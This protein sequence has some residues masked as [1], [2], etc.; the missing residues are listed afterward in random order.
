MHDS[1]FQFVKTEKVNETVHENMLVYF[2]ISL[3][4]R[5]MEAHKVKKKKK[6]YIV[7]IQTPIHTVYMLAFCYDGFCNNKGG[8]AV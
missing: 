7:Y 2:L 3:E 1:V 4:N 8:R 6:W 5:K